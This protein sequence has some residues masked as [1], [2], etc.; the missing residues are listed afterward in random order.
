MIDV[1][2]TDTP[3][4]AL[5]VLAREGVVIAAGFRPPEQIFERLKPADQ[6]P[7]Q[8]VAS[9]GTISDAIQAWLDGCVDALDEIP[10]MQPGSQL[11]QE[12]W[13]G[14][15]GIKAG[16]TKTYT[17]LAATTS[18]PSAIRAAGSACAKNLVA[19]IIPCH[20][21]VRKDGSLGGYYYGL[22]VKRWLIDHEHKAAAA[23]TKPNLSIVTA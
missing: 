10:V 6:G 17:E 22:D 4:I 16:E 9:L 11:Q 14:L 7:M 19:P 21:A 12:V 1:W 23:S 20:R 18:R 13:V 15:R 3:T 2:T 5:S 8:Q